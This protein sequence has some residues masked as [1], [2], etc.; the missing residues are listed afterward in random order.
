MRSITKT[1]KDND[2]T[3]CEGVISIEYDIEQW[4]PVRQCAVY[5]KMW[6][7]INVTYR[8]SLLYAKNETELSC[9]IW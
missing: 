1:K 5:E 9:P 3:N 4:R 8:T 7:D 2:G 6:Q